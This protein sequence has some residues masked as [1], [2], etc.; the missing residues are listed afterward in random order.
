MKPTA[1]DVPPSMHLNLQPTEVVCII[2]IIIKK[3]KLLITKT[4]EVNDRDYVTRMLY[5]SFAIR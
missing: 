4:A 5:L 1:I 3:K 2:I